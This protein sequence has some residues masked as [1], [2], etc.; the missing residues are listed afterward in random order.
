MYRMAGDIQKTCLAYNLNLSHIN[1]EAYTVTLAESPQCKIMWTGWG[2]LGSISLEKDGQVVKQSGK[3]S[4]RRCAK[5]LNRVSA[6][7][8]VM[9]LRAQEDHVEDFLQLKM[10][11]DNLLANVTYT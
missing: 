11:Q 2:A 6:E 5:F 4:P 8:F 7:P 9:L 3:K 1:M 10:R